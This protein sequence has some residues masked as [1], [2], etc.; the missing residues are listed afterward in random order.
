MR[1]NSVRILTSGKCL[2]FPGSRQVVWFVSGICREHLAWSTREVILDEQCG[3]NVVVDDVLQRFVLPDLKLF[4]RTWRWAQKT[5][6]KPS[7]GNRSVTQHCHK[8]VTN[9]RVRDSPVS[10]HSTARQ[11]ERW[12]SRALRVLFLLIQHGQS[13]VS[14][15]VKMFL[16]TSGTVAGQDFRWAQVWHTEHKS[17]GIDCHTK[18]SCCK[19]CMCATGCGPFVQR[20]VVLWRPTNEQCP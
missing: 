13:D 12:R 9:N 14:F 11:H 20:W 19:R 10:C 5:K 2:E 6:T 8:D 17:D 1:W 4:C 16:T 7:H 3:A 15:S 18:S